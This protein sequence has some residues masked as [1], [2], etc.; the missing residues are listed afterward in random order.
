MQ[1]KYGW[2][3]FNG[4]SKNQKLLE[5]VN[6]YKNI[7]TELYIDL[8]LIKNTEIFAFLHSEKFT[9]KTHIKLKYPDFILFLDKDINLAKAL[10]S[11]GYKVFNSS[12]V[13]NICDDKI[14]TH[15]YLSEKTIIKSP[16]TI[17]PPL[18]FNTCK[19]SAGE[20]VKFINFLES[21]LKY[22]IVIKEA[23]GSFGEQVYL[24]KN[25]DELLSK[26]ES[27]NSTPHLYQEFITSSF[28]KDI[29]IHIVGQEYVTSMMRYSKTDFRSNI[30]SGAS[31]KKVKPS[32]DFINMAIEVSKALQADFIGVD[33]LIGVHGEPIFCEVNSNA[34][35]K[36]ISD[37]TG[38]NIAKKIFNHIL[39]KI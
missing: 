38:I 9:I 14:L 19:E 1:K 21:E 11:S 6:Y 18:I 28:G 39:S 22:P 2:L 36:N 7:A 27:L 13:L 37:L 10:E 23:K 4:N 33:I 35:I 15:Q 12:K 17:L 30:N 32:Q 24:V 31:F 25:R 34:Y 8:D 29:R 26:K 20:Q 16:K 3:I 5:V